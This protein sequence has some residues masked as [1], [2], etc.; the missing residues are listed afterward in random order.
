MPGTP[1][2]LWLIGMMGAGKTLVGRLVAERLGREF[3]DTDEE[4]ERRMRRSIPEVWE[5]HGESGFREV[6]EATVRALAGTGAVVATGGGV[7]TRPDSVAVMRRSGLV[8]W[9]EAAPATLAVRV[10][11]GQGRPLLAGGVSVEERLA[12]L[13]VERRPAYAAAAHRQIV[14]DGRSP[15]E[16]ADE[17]VAIWEEGRWSGS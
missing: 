3:A 15:E 6:E 7:V 14:T 5:A 10:G 8:V 1:P 2:G 16:V 9:L 17:V 12:A 11:R 4:V 13:A